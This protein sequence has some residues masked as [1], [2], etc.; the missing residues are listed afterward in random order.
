MD[1]AMFFLSTEEV[2]KEVLSAVKVKIKLVAID[3]DG[4]LF[5]IAE[6]G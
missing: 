5:L 2:I 4:S 6:L 3:R 1:L